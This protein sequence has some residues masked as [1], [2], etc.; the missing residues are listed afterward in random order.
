M[1][2]RKSAELFAIVFLVAAAAIPTSVS[3]ASESASTA[4]APDRMRDVEFSYQSEITGIDPRA[5]VLEVWIPLPRKDKFQS[6][7]GFAL[8]SPLHL[9]K[10]NKDGDGNSIAYLKATAPFAAS[11]PISFSFKLHRV[12]QSANLVQ[13]QAGT[14]P[15][16]GDMAKFLHANRLVPTDG[17]ITQV[18]A[19]VGH[20]ATSPYD[21]ARAIY[22]YVVA[23][24]KYDKTGTGWGRGDAIYACDI[25]KG[26]CTDF[27]S[28]F[29][30]IA[31]S[32]GIPA[33]F[34]I[35]FP[36]GPS[37]SGQIPG[38][39]CWAEF[40]AGGQ[41]VPVDASEASKHPERRNYYFGH[42]DADRVAF[43]QGRDLIMNPPQHGAP[44][45]FLIYPYV[46]ID[47]SPMPQKQVKNVWHYSDV[48]TTN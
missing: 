27:H 36:L 19:T 3:L 8:Q 47:G 41:W 15:A 11:I 6:I 30:A 24:M 25:K 34:T 1:A 14:E 40:Y 21:Q 33:R 17:K 7:S 32:R 26:N 2:L 37:G 16:D 31:R 39:H 46:E 23:T 22:D 13:A 45:N 28:L 35:G 43:T 48:R 42:L 9:E 12:E 44:L 4:A 29:I 10:I 5:H 20:T 38:Y 18:S